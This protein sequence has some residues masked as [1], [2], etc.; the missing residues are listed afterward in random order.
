MDMDEQ[1][2]ASV[3]S[4][5]ETPAAGGQ[6]PQGDALPGADASR[7]AGLAEAKERF[8]ALQRRLRE[9]AACLAEKQELARG[10]TARARTRQEAAAELLEQQRFLSREIDALRAE[11][12]ERQGA[13]AAAEAG[14]R[15]RL[16]GIE[17]AVRQVEFLRGELAALRARRDAV[18]GTVPETMRDKAHLDSKITG[19]ARE[20]DDIARQVRAAE[21][22][23]KLAYYQKRQALR[24]EHEPY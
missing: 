19:S 9:A 6:T 22:E 16:A 18:K 17:K 11:R 4:A 1:A 13:L 7:P 5:G 23:F 10:E 14:L 2:A 15:D 8:R 24:R 21:L 20:F 3:E 12:D